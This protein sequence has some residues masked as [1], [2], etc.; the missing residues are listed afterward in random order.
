MCIRTCL[1]WVWK[2]SGTVSGIKKEMSRKFISCQSQQVVLPADTDWKVDK[3]LSPDL[4]G[5]FF[6]SADM[7]GK[8]NR[9]DDGLLNINACELLIVHNF[10]PFLWVFHF[11]NKHQLHHLGLQ[12]ALQTLSSAEQNWTAHGQVLVRAGQRGSPEPVLPLSLLV[13]ET[14]ASIWKS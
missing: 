11:R 12:G 6:S 3:S 5:I 4:I 7:R 14:M 13:D 2:S 8:M 9:K 1:R 10:G